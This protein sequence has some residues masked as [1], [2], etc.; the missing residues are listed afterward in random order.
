[1]RGHTE[2]ELAAPNAP[3][4]EPVRRAGADGA[5]CTIRAILHRR[6]VRRWL[7]VGGIDLLIQEAGAPAR[8]YMG[9]SDS[10][11]KACAHDAP[12]ARSAAHWIA[13]PAGNEL[14]SAIEGSTSSRSASARGIGRAMSGAI[15]FI[16]RLRIKAAYSRGASTRLPSIASGELP[17][18][19]LT[20]KNPSRFFPSIIFLTVQ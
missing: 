12:C 1:M 17:C 20:R 8:A 19:T 4:G 16:R 7:R 15:G 5:T 13:S 2:A 9:R 10:W 18:S 6:G 14:V 11:V 3:D